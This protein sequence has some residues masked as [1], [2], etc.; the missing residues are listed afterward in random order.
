MDEFKKRLLGN[1]TSEPNILSFDDDINIQEVN[2]DE[3][4]ELKE[5]TKKYASTLKD[6][7]LE[8]VNSASSSQQ[9]YDIDDDI[10]EKDRPEFEEDNEDVAEMK[11]KLGLSEKGLYRTR[12]S[13]KRDAK[14]RP[15]EKPP[16]MT[17]AELLLFKKIVA[18][19]M[20]DG[21]ESSKQ[22]KVDF[23]FIEDELN[24]DDDIY[25]RENTVEE[26]TEENIRLMNL[27]MSMQTTFDTKKSEKQINKIL[28]DERYQLKQERKK[29]K[30]YDTYIDLKYFSAFHM[31]SIEW[32]NALL[33][34]QN[35]ETPFIYLQ[36]LQTAGVGGVPYKFRAAVYFLE[37]LGMTV[38][39]ISETTD[40]CKYRAFFS[41]RQFHT[42]TD[43]EITMLK[44]MIKEKE[45]HKLQ[46]IPEGGSSA[47]TSY[48]L[49]PD[50]YQEMLKS[51][52]G[53]RGI[54]SLKRAERMARQHEKPIDLFAS[55]PHIPTEKEKEK[56]RKEKVMQM[57]MQLGKSVEI[58]DTDE[59]N[60][61]ED[62]EIQ[63]TNDE[64]RDNYDHFLGGFTK[65][66]I[67]SL[68]ES[69]KFLDMKSID[70]LAKKQTELSSW[71]EKRLCIDIMIVPGLN[72]SSMVDQK[73]ERQL[74]FVFNLISQNPY[75]FYL[76]N[77]GRE[78]RNLSLAIKEMDK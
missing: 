41:G 12:I 13:I 33:N 7:I 38:N 20:I 5:S 53:E 50:S 29:D 4:E 67:R 10:D 19:A 68:E 56:K 23:T 32:R 69:S 44:E 63:P 78:E 75:T 77:V 6:K 21:I 61:D 57:E 18:P 59:E 49:P 58:D 15:V 22:P 39:V 46:R 45:K 31:F 24:D 26:E 72:S 48:E 42:A 51:K 62:E 43:N 1:A 14:F 47:Q 70:S 52:S 76:M 66:M 74:L 25:N 60:S 64:I 9:D 3:V 16:S 37:A 2:E 34:D 35:V 11:R 73:I 65:E 55:A 54:E 8:E 71:I 28:E 40:A 27:V 30:K 17:E 36:S